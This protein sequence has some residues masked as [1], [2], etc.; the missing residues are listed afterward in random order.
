MVNEGKEPPGCKNAHA[1]FVFDIKYDGRHKAKILANGNLA[2]VPLYSVYLDVVS[3]R[4]IRLFL[5]IS[6]LNNL[7][8]WT[9][10]VVNSYLE[11]KTKEKFY[12]L[13]CPE[14]VCLK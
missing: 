5:F 3:L 4:C 8:F 13:V 11:A 7:K 9:N 6:E 14:F 12:I 10:C 2:E 1:H